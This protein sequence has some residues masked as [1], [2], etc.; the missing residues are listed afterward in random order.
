[1]SRKLGSG[2][3]GQLGSVVLLLSAV[4]CVALPAQSVD[5]DAVWQFVTEVP[6]VL[7]RSDLPPQSAIVR[8]NRAA[9]ERAVSRAPRNTA[10]AATS[11]VIVTLPMPDRTLARFR[12]AESSMLAPELA[13]AYPEIRTYLGQGV[14]DR[15]ATVRFGWT[16]KGF[17]A[18]VLGVTGDVYIDPYSPASTEYYLTMRKAQ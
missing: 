12:V 2:A 3:V 4:A 14:D 16:E 6:G 11:D 8:F 10:S 7:A 13:A 17:H 18:L 1:M 9:F 5:A 15:T